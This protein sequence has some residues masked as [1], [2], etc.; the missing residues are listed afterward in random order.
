[1]TTIL[2]INSSIFGDD[3]KSSNLAN[4]FVEELRTRKPN[5]RVVRRDLAKDPI[6]HLNAETFTASTI[7]IEERT[8]EQAQVVAVADTLVDELVAADI[9]VIGSPT[10]NFGISS[11]LKTWFDHVARAG[12][13]FRYTENGPEGLLSIDAYVFISSGGLYAGTDT[14]FQ[15]NY[16]RHYL[17][18]LGINNIEFTYLEGIAMGDD[19]LNKGI[20]NANDRIQT[21]VA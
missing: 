6:S 8:Q 13:T 20:K 3:G 2:Q 16:I 15:T 19:T 5:A 18:F 9:L 7:P 21:L 12:V 17:N 1:M 11:S 4:S 10:Y 14:D